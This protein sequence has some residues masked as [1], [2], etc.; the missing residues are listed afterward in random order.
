MHFFNPAPVQ[1]LVELVVSLST[2]DAAVASVEGFA[3]DVLGKHVIHARDRAGF[4]VNRLLVPYLL[5]A[6]RMLDSGLATRED[7]DDGMKLGCAHPMGPLEL[8]DLIGLDTCKSVADVLYE[9]FKELAY[10]PPPLLARMVAAGQ[11]GRKTGRGF[12]EY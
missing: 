5:S 10:A 8:C 2:S 6:I 1:P 7:I 9:E 4:I 11:L 3:T 12:Y